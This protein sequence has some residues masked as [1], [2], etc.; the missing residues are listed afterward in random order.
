[1]RVAVESFATYDLLRTEGLG[2]ASDRRDKL[3]STEIINSC[4][5]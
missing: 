5:R 1:M 3:V 4:V 2:Q